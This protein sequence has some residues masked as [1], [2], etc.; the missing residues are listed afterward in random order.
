MFVVERL[1]QAGGALG[2]IY[3]IALEYSDWAENGAIVFVTS[4]F[5][6]LCAQGFIIYQKHRPRD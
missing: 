2:A 5:A 1:I 4:V 3:G 6:I